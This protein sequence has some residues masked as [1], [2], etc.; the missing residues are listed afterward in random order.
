MI[1]R[2][3]FIK[4]SLLFT[5]YTLISDELSFA[6]ALND[7]SVKA[8]TLNIT[9]ATEILKPPK[10]KGVNIWIPIPYHDFEQEVSDFSVISEIPYKTTEDSRKNKMLFLKKETVKEGDRIV[11]K[12]ILRRKTSGIIEDTKDK[13]EKYLKPSEWEKWD[14]NI[15]KYVGYLVGNEKDSVKIGRKVY[16]AII[17]HLKYI[18]EVC[19]R[20]VSAIT[21]EDRIGRCD[22][23]HA[24]FRSMMMYKKIPVKWEQGLA[25]PYPSEMKKTGEFEADC[26]NAHSWVRFYTGKNRWMPVDVSEGKRRPDI[27]EFYFGNLVPNRIKFSTGRGITLNPP[28]KNI[29]NTF[30]YTYMEAGGIPAI[31]GHNYRSIFKY[32]LVKIEV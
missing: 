5:G 8:L 21:F 31:Y 15:S 25:L 20:G 2:R 29:M 9:Y 16:H 17:D 7:Q 11:L 14:E 26:I 28:Q 27:R 10:K 3:A 24:L 32:E 19:G 18:H 22:E 4:N 1:N 6:D 30:P 13:P 12:Y 23:F